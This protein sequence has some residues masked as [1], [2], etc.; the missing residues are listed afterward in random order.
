VQPQWYAGTT[1]SRHE[2]RVAQQ[3]EERSIEHFLPL[4][5]TVH[6]WRNGRHRLELP[7]FP[8]YIFVRLP[9]RDRLR[10]LQVP[11]FVSLVAF[12]GVPCPLPEVEINSIR[13]ALSHGL[14]AEPYPYLSEGDRVELRS[15][16]LAGMKGILLRRPNKY[17]V[18]LSVD[19]IMRSIV[20][21][22][23]ASDIAPAD[24]RVVASP[25]FDLI[26]LEKRL[27]G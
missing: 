8:G 3:F 23:D 10:V 5:Q 24:G 11:G 4:Y 21:D 15:G 25:D 16:P 9:W 18:V 1:C 27:C 22:V 7:L 26:P 2:K 17:R 12:G 20:V 6:Q 13:T 19:L 14:M